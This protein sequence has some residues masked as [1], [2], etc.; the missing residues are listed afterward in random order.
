MKIRATIIVDY[1]IPEKDFQ[2]AY[3]TQDPAKVLVKEQEYVEGDGDYIIMLLG[4]EDVNS[5]TTVE[6]VQ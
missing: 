3:G 4:S 2:A 5:N 1:D 6:W